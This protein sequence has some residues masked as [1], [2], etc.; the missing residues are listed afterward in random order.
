MKSLILLLLWSVVC[1][2]GTPGHE[3]IVVCSIE[4][5]FKTPLWSFY[6]HI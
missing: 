2:A 4:L 3:T 5:L 6:A 1:F